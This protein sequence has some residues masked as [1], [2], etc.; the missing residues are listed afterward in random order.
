MCNQQLTSE[1]YWKAHIS[2]REHKQVRFVFKSN[3]LLPFFFLNIQKLLELKSNIKQ[4]DEESVFSKPLPPSPV[5]I[6]PQRG[7][8]RPHDVGLSVA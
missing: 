2:G 1:T 5:K 8:K 6:H 4:S 7:V 3:L